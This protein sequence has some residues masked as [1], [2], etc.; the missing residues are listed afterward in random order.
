MPTDPRMQLRNSLFLALYEAHRS[1]SREE[2]VK[3][4]EYVR[5]WGL[6]VYDGPPDECRST[7]E[8]LLG[9]DL[10]GEEDSD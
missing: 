9:P 2:F 5:T 10:L 7:L 6:R 3:E 4:L 1:V 8:R